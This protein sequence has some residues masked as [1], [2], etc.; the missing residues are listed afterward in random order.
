VTESDASRVIARTRFIESLERAGLRYVDD[1]T[2]RGTHSAASGTVDFL[3][4]LDETFP[5]MPPTV[6]VEPEDSVPWSW[7]RYRD[8]SMCLYTDDD[9]GTTPWLDVGSFL[10]HVGNWIDNTITGWTTDNPDMDLD[11]YFPRSDRPQLVLYAGLD[12]YKTP[13]IML[14]TTAHT[15]TVVGEARAPKKHRPRNR[16]Y[17]YVLD[18]GSPL[19]P[20]RTWSHI[21]ALANAKDDVTQLVVEGLIDVV[22]VRYRRGDA[23]GVLTLDAQLTADGVI[24]QAMPTAS[25]EATVRS[26]RAGPQRSSLESAHVHLVG[27]GALGSFIADAL[28]RGGLGNLVVQDHDVVRPGNLVRHLV[29]WEQV[30]MNKGHAIKHY[31]D[32]TTYS[33][34]TIEASSMAMLT[35]EQA[36][37]ALNSCDLLIDATASSVATSVLAH[38]ARITGTTIL[39]ACLQ[40]D[41]E[42]QRVDVIPPLSGQPIPQ[43][44]QRGSSAPAIYEGGCGS[45]VSPTPPYAVIEAAAMT[46]AHAVGVLTR[47]PLSPNGELRDRVGP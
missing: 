15:A 17:G 19:E 6:L 18:I 8:G 9:H 5:F 27:G 1:A 45:P 43:S 2:C 32:G 31:L 46:V 34:C 38:A 4:R 36:L 30:G 10:T 24:A 14:R 20:P 33:S 37:D 13:F 16:L 26:L 42:T 40:N 23:D 39:A 11:R 3:V 28:V 44:P 29:G 35:L 21:V 7:H 22:L 12:R 41:G 25:N 47:A